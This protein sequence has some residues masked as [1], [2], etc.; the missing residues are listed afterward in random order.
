VKIPYLICP[1]PRAGR[2]TD[3]KCTILRQRYK[4]DTNELVNRAMSKKAEHDTSFN[5]KKLFESNSSIFIAE[6]GGNR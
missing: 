1:L 5:S 3:E 4:I 2:K 6:N